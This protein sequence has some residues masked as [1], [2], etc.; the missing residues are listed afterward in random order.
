[1]CLDDCARVSCLHGDC[2]AA[3]EERERESVVAVRD[4]GCQV[5][6]RVGKFTSSLAHAPNVS[7][8]KGRTSYVSERSRTGMTFVTSHEKGN[9]NLFFTFY[10]N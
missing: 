1:M 2:E 5:R 7:T 8:A 6:E 4:P 9:I 10:S 3:I